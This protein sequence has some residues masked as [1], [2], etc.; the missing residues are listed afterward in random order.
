MS[1][2]QLRERL[3][4]RAKEIRDLVEGNP[5][6][7][8]SPDLQGKYDSG[9][10]EIES[11]KAEIKR[12]QGLMDTLAANDLQKSMATA[13]DRIEHK[14]RNRHDVVK[15]LHAKWLRGGDNA[16]SAEDWGV[17][18]TMSTSTSSEGGYTVMTEV[19]KSVAD[20]L[21]AYGGMRAPGM[22]T[23]IQSVNGVSIN[24]PTSDGTSEEGE[25]VD[26][27]ATTTDADIA[28]GVVSIPV[29]KFSS[30]VVTVPI[31]LLQDSSI[32]VE[33]FVNQR[34]VTRIGRAT[35]RK[36]SVGTGT[37]E[38][39]GVVSAAIAGKIG[40]SGQTSTVTYD[41]LVDLVHSVDPAYRESG[42]CLFMLNDDSMKIIRKI[43]DD[44]N[45]PVFLPGYDGLAGPMPDT[46]LGYKVTVNQHVSTMTAGAKSILFGDFSH[47]IIRDVL[48]GEM[49]RFTDSA[50]AKKGQVGFLMFSRHGGNFT[51]VGGAVKYYQ[52]AAS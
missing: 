3:N 37:N 48:G 11:I 41:D 7:K 22:A 21:K 5:G 6:D 33:A 42:N 4:A 31:E 38:P 28:F 12:H 32:D 26:Q 40:A 17:F 9:M 30:K 49:F 34:L 15:A 16:L 1:V 51:D 25:I 29:Y 35:N 18:N 14:N 47:Y 23:V 45:R 52:N 13:A 43:K 44:Q 27:N 46:I 36:F 8:W 39:K 20:A 50:Y 2:Q 10:T 24:Y 19:A